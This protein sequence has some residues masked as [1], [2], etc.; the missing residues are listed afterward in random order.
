MMQK[1]KFGLT[2]FQL[3]IIALAAM[4]VDHI[5]SFL[6]LHINDSLYYIMRS[7]GRVA[8]PVFLFLVAEG[9]RHT[10]DRKKYIL[11]FYIAGAILTGINQLLEDTLAQR[12]GFFEGF[13]NTFPM[14]L[15]TALYVISIE[16]L[17]QARKDR[18]LKAVCLSILGLA[19]PFISSFFYPSVQG[20]SR[21]ME[22]AFRMFMPTMGEI[23]YSFLFVLLGTAWYFI[24]NT[25]RSALLLTGLSVLSGVIYLFGIDVPVFWQVF[26]GGQ[27]CMILAAP[28]LLFY[29]GQRGR[30][31][32]YLFYIYYP[33]H[34]YLL[35]ILALIL[36]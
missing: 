35:F 19:A 30:S 28:L 15:Y 21:V 6:F 4:T 18:D 10:G 2:N 16:K 5:A 26:T 14:F 9:L 13:S 11:R 33:L 8:A 32:K 29:N 25:R 7:I 20:E 34:Q 17:W 3:K 12:L 31:C 22:I 1:E 23:E 27:W 24:N 36:A